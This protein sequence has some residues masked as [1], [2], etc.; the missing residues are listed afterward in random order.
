MGNVFGQFF[1]RS[2]PNVGADPHRS[3]QFGPGSSKPSAHPPDSYPCPICRHGQVAQMPLMEALSC[4]FCRHIFTLNPRTPHSPRLNFVL[5][6][7]DVLLRVEDS[8]QPL[9]WRWSGR[10]W[11][12]LR[13]GGS[14]EL[15]PALWFLGGLLAIAPAS[16][17]ALGRYMF[18][19]LPDSPGANLGWGWL[20]LTLVA[21]WGLVAWVLLEHYQLAWYVS[22]KLRWQDWRDR[23]FSSL[24]R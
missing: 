24:Q 5:D 6:R 2:Q 21:H 19:P 20:G 9:T 18:P 12:P 13:A 10:D 3:R 1:R 8:V 11:R 15:S 22:L 7:P 4:D 23:A 14:A 16:L 17:I